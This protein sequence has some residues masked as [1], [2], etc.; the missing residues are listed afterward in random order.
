MHAYRVKAK[1][2]KEMV[3]RLFQNAQEKLNSLCASKFNILIYKSQQEN[4]NSL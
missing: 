2:N 4:G 3:L 1:S